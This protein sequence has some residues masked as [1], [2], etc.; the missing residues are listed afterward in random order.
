MIARVILFGLIFF[1]WPYC[2]THTF[3]C[4]GQSEEARIAKEVEANQKRIKKEFEKQDV[5]K[6]KVFLFPLGTCW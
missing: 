6:R 3:M 1:I 4:D 5:L 2:F